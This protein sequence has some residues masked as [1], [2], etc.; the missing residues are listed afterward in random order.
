MRASPAELGKGLFVEVVLCFSGTQSSFKHM[1]SDKDVAAETV[2]PCLVQIERA[3]EGGVVG[4]AD[5]RVIVGDF[6]HPTERWRVL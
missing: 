1:T 4:I 2:S 5:Q 6:S 3:G